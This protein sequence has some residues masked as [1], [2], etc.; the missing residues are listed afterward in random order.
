MREYALIMLI[1][2][3]Y[4]CLYLNKQSFEFARVLEVC[5]GT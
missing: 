5:C 4:A 2:L 3:E 1:M